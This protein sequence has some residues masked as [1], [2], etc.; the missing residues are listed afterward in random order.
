MVQYLIIV[1]MGGC[2][3]RSRHDEVRRELDD[4]RDEYNALVMK[5]RLATAARG[6]VVQDRNLLFDA[7]RDVSILKAQLFDTSADLLELGHRTG[8]TVIMTSFSLNTC[9]AFKATLL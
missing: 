9:I 8:D 3:S 1:N 4:L 7:T 5:H 6:R 2:V